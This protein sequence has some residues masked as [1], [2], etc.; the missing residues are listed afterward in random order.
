MLDLGLKPNYLWR[1]ISSILLAI[2]FF[3]DWINMAASI[4][5]TAVAAT[6]RCVCVCVDLQCSHIGLMAI[7]C[8]LPPNYSLAGIA[9]PLMPSS[10][11]YNFL[12]GLS[13]PLLPSFLGASVTSTCWRYLPAEYLVLTKERPRYPALELAYVN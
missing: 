5:T 12:R 11:S 13:G 6:L 10:E 3:A 7:Y 2:L 1:S 4:Q 8:D 9:P